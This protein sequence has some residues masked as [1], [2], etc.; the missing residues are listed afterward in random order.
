MC[1]D[2]TPGDTDTINNCSQPIP[3]TVEAQA[4][5]SL[6][7]PVAT[8]RD[9]PQIQGPDLVIPSA[10]VESPTVMIGGGVRLHITL[11]NQGTNAAPATTIRYYRSLDATISAAD[12]E[13]R[14][15]NVGQI[16]AGKSTTTWALLLSPTVSGVY[17]YGACVD[18]CR[19][20]IRYIEQ[21]LCCDSSHSGSARCRS[22]VAIAD[23]DNSCTASGGWRVAGGTGCIGQLCGAG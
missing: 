16:G 10:R 9:T 2:A 19:L 23:R 15:V 21:L 18:A 22:E 4:P 5:A 6:I 13:L 11:T 14:A 1:V 20:R 3:I 7:P 12:T 17:Y 8:K